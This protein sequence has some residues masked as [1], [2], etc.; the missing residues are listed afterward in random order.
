MVEEVPVD[1]GCG[2][3]DVEVQHPPGQALVRDGHGGDVQEGGEQRFKGEGG[4]A[5]RIVAV[6][7]AAVVIPNG[8]SKGQVEKIGNYAVE[9]KHLIPNR[10]QSLGFD[11]GRHLL[12]AECQADVR[13]TH[14]VLVRRKQV[15]P[16]EKVH[17]DNAFREDVCWLD[18][19]GGRGGG[20]GCGGCGGGGSPR[21][22]EP[23][24]PLQRQVC[25]EGV[26]ACSEQR[27][28][29]EVAHADVV[30]TGGLVVVIDGDDEAV[31]QKIAKHAV[32]LQR[33]VPHR[34]KRLL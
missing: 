27:L 11:R 25:C 8:Q 24:L 17:A 33:F 1:C 10:V 26:F 19:A 34:I 12:R 2:P 23:D 13:I 15:L 4:G 3:A 18:G 5:Q 21:D 14:A 16:R 28:E 29:R 31:V 7:G 30:V 9:L 20:G 22:L 32:P 6:E